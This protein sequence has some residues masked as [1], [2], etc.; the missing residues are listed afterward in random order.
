VAEN[1]DAK[2]DERF[3]LGLLID[4]LTTRGE[5]GFHCKLNDSDP[6]DLIITWKREKRRGW[7][8]AG[9]INKSNR[10]A[11]Q[12]LF[13]QRVSARFCG[14]LATSS[15]KRQQANATVAILTADTAHSAPPGA[16]HGIP[17]SHGPARPLVTT[18][19]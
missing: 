7:K 13:L 4:H 14:L 8:S 6:P 5:A 16:P 12:R 1:T 19:G 9:R 18:N 15:R 17:R 11:D 2:S 10:S 3:A